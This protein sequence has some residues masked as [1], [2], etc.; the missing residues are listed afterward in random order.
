[1]NINQQ[2]AAELSIRPAQADAAIALIDEGNTVPF[3]ARYRK[4]MTGALDDTQLRDLYD[5]LNALRNLEKR[6][7][8]IH[9]AIEQLQAMTPELSR[10]ILAAKTL[11]ALEVLYLPYKKKRR[12]RASI[13]KEKGLEPLALTLFAQNNPDNPRNL[14]TPFI[15]DEL[16]V[17]TIDEALAGA[18]DIIAEMISDNAEVRGKLRQLM[19]K[20]AVISSSGSGEE[21]STYAMYQQLSEPVGKIA[22]HRLLA[23]N[24]GE[25]EGVL[26]VAVET[27]MGAALYVVEEQVIKPGG[28]PAI[29]LVKT[30]AAGALKRLI[31]PSLE[32]ELRNS[33]F[34]T[35]SE[36]AIKVFALNLKPLLLQPPLK[37]RVTLGFDPAYRT[38]CKL[39]VVDATGRVLTTTVIYPTPPQNKLEQ[40]TATVKEL[41]QRYEITA[42]A[43]GNGTASKES[44]IFVAGLLKELNTPVQYMVVSEAGAS[45]YSAS[46]LAA[47]EFPQYDV[48]LRSAVSIARRLQDP[49]AELVKIDPKSIG[50]GQYQHDMPA[51]RLDEALGGVVEDCVNSVGVDVNTASHS[52]LAYVAGIGPALAKSIVAFREENGHFTSR[53]QLNQVPKLGKKAYQQAAG[54]LR[55]PESTELL[56]HTAVHP[57][58]YPAAKQLLELCGYRK[59]DLAQGN[60][61]QL[62]QKVA[63][64]GERQLAESIGVGL[65]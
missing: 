49:L 47:E 51:K 50:V 48:S 18:Q 55:V 2:I 15:N 26:K 62:P 59:A 31:Y 13:A 1:M 44:E 28:N 64:I 36:Q 41:I 5:R 39:A 37:G 45:V 58:S 46:K 60:L 38:G 61:R 19:S 21:N 56:D 30:A 24:R 23:I 4:E 8:E 53:K 6:R 20:T 16:G 10:D 54:F 35:A 52:L 57:E 9:S 25:K 40:A 7:T 33:L 65:P 29:E 43:I 34:E 27:A 17:A 63:D 32:N 3:I 22:P 12:T 42:I 14:A 11:T